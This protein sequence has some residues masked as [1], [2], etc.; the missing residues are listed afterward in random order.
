MSNM[1]IFYLILSILTVI[2]VTNI[3]CSEET[4]LNRSLHTKIIGGFDADIKS[5]PYIVSIRKQRTHICGGAYIHK[6]WVL[7]A[8][9]CL[10]ESKSKARPILSNV[11][12]FELRMGAT[13]LYSNEAQVRIPKRLTI[14]SNYNPNIYLHDIALVK[15]KQPFIAS[16]TVGLIGIVKKE[17][18]YNKT[19][20]KIAGWGL[21][22][23]DANEETIMLKMTSLQ[24]IPKEKC[25]EIYSGRAYNDHFK[26]NKVIC[27]G[28]SKHDTC[29][30]DSGG[31]LVYKN[32]VI[33]LTSFGAGCGSGRP[34][35]YTNVYYYRNWF[36]TMLPRSSRSSGCK[37][38]FSS[39]F[40]F[41]Y[42][43]YFIYLE[44]IK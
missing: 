32:L 44:E 5:F 33:G 28:Y 22:D 38:T 40:L 39:Y 3:Y 35:L 14:H 36:K 2:L 27:A 6:F 10:V 15:I 17:P 23:P 7:T 18:N 34:T 16:E 21:T 42:Y 11:N 43:L 31:P 4:P 19:I 25:K 24:I 9:H 13:S 29:T 26:D 12:N 20:A 30:G 37:R 1:V 41:I 8:A